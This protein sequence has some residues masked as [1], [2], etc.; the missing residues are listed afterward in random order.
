MYHVHVHA[1]VYVYVHV[2]V[3][4]YVYVYVFV[5]VYLTVIEPMVQHEFVGK[6]RKCKNLSQDT[7]LNTRGWHRQ[8]EADL[9]AKHSR[10]QIMSR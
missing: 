8:P 4:V 1:Y 6:L 5:Y 9:Q 2:H 7:N 3:H 10:Q